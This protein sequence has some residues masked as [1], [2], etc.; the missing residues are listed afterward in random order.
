M[1]PGKPKPSTISA[2]LRRI[3]E[4]VSAGC[5]SPL[6]GLLIRSRS[7]HRSIRINRYWALIMAI[8]S[9]M[10]DFLLRIIQTRIIQGDRFTDPSVLM[11]SIADSH[12]VFERC[13]SEPQEVFE[14][15]ST[16]V[17]FLR[18]RPCCSLCR[19]LEAG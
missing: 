10:S 2:A 11:F 13:S 3:T 7:T 4:L 19:R 6:G 9:N 1:Q 14:Y 8:L 5:K 18:D 17:G 15:S 16:R 12:Y